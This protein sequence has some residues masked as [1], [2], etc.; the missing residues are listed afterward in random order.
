MLVTSDFP[1]RSWAWEPWRRNDIF[2]RTLPE[3][4]WVVPGQFAALIGA[5]KQ[6]L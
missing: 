5:P 2:C 4:L 6:P 1:D 3:A